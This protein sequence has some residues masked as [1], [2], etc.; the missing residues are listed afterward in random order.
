[1]MRVRRNNDGEDGAREVL[2]MME[3]VGQDDG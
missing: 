3:D 2:T 1:M